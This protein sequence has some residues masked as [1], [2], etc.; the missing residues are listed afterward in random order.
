M[1]GALDS[2]RPHLLKM[3]L[4]NSIINARDADALRIWIRVFRAEVAA[5]TAS[6]KDAA[7]RPGGGGANSLASILTLDRQLELEETLDQVMSPLSLPLCL[8]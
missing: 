1:G 8:P 2:H 3:K 4:L 6:I 5:A 7:A